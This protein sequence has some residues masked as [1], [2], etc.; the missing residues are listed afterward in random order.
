[1]L[2]KNVKIVN[3]NQIIECADIEF[4]KKITKITPTKN[5]AQYLLVP[6]FIDTH[7]HGFMNKDVMDSSA[8]VEDISLN[9]ARNGI[10]SFMPTAMTASWENIQIA[11]KNIAL[12]K[13][14]GAKNIGIHIE[15]PFIGEAKKGAHKL[16]WLRRATREDILEML[17]SSNHQLK[18]ISYDPLMVEEKLVPFMVQIDIM[19]SIGH[20]AASYDQ[21][22][23]YYDLGSTNTCHL[24]NAMSGIDSRKPGILEA[25]LERHDVY[26]ELIVDFHHICQ[27]S[28]VFTLNHKDINHLMCVSDAIRPAYGP[29]GKSISGGINI[30]KHGLTIYLEGTTTIAGSGICLH[31][32]FKNLASLDLDYRD[33]VK[34]TSYN[35]AKAHNLKDR[36][37]IKANKLADLV[38]MDLKTLDIKEVYIDG[39]KVK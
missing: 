26:S 9:L 10:T 1:M 39:Q 29:D 6:G 13:C 15:G 35:A 4:S 28:I 23:K 30:E 31:D 7:I 3:H 27:E 34:L 11:L 18:K 19:P 24:W 32:S 12:A 22:M 25:S 20:S 33:I 14:Q 16:E 37:Q 2:I 36:A 8:A 38:L 21:A 17:N 5:K